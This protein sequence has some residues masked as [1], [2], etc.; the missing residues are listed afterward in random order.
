[1]KV[2]LKNRGSLFSGSDVSATFGVMLV[3]GECV[4]RVFFF[5]FQYWFFWL[6]LLLLQEGLFFFSSLAIFLLPMIHPCYSLVLAELN[7]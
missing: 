3:V 7:S 1:M 6:A 2:T 4:W 5:A